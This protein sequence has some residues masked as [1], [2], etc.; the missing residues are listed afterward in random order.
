MDQHEHVLAL[1][2]TYIGSI[3]K[4]EHKMW[5]LN[6]DTKR[7]EYKTIQFVPGLYKIFDEIVTNAR[8]H[9]VRDKTCNTIKINI[10]KN[11]GEITCWNNGKNGIPVEIHKEHNMYVPEMIF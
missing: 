8:D 2:D 3:E 7:I 11:T 1:P 6:E 9:S 4:D 5:V 10:D